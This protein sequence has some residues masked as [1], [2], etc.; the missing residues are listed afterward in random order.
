V[1]L[2]LFLITLAFSYA[3]NDVLS[4]SIPKEKNALQ[5]QVESIDFGDLAPRLHLPQQ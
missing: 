2:I 4:N 1:S 5:T 3:S